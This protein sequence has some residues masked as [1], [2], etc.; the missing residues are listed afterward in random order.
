[1]NLRQ[2]RHHCEKY[3]ST[4]GA[5]FPG[6]PLK[7][8]AGLVNFRAPPSPFCLSAFCYLR[9]RTVLRTVHHVALFCCCGPAE[10]TIRVI[11]CWLSG[12]YLSSSWI[13]L[14]AL[15]FVF[16]SV[17]NMK[18][19]RRGRSPLRVEGLHR[20]CR[21]TRKLFEVTFWLPRR[22]PCQPHYVPLT[23]LAFVTSRRLMAGFQQTGMSSRLL[24]FL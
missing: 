5:S 10:L 3:L 19:R 21:R 24:L 9:K 12:E 20:P 4:E 1:M 23:R 2:E 11:S 17:E 13:I 16:V 15:E 22:D 7:N 8:H 18:S 14:P 6:N